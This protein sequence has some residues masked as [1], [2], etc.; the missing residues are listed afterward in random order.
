LGYNE[1]IVIN[2]TDTSAA[3][4]NKGPEMNIYFN[5]LSFRP[6]D[7]I[8]EAPVLIVNLKDESGINAAGSGI[9]HRIEAWLDDQ[10]QSTDLTQYYKSKL[11][12]YQ[13]G[14]VEYQFGKLSPGTH[15]LRLRA[16]DV[17]NNASTSET[18]FDVLVS[19]GLKISEVFNYPN[20]FSGQTA[21]TFNH[22]QILPVDTEIKI[23]TIAGRQVN[24]IKK[25]NITDKFVKVEWDGRDK[26][27]DQ[28]ANGIYL[29]KIILKTQDGRFT[30]EAL[31]KLSILR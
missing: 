24:S 21:F 22:N 5:S 15:S 3:Q 8:P 4:D 16:W 13:E 17:F 6:G 2:G 9:G 19:Q 20:P 29:Y 31:G 10:N 18:I 12:T 7:V 30:S 25:A 23:Y 27:G 28:L 14:I 1:N 26:E 11:D